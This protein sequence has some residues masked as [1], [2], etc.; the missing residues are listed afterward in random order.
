MNIRAYGFLLSQE[1][2][3]GVL[4]HAGAG[5]RRED[6]FIDRAGLSNETRPFELA[7]RDK[8][9]NFTHLGSPRLENYSSI[10]WSRVFRTETPTLITRC[11][12]RTSGAR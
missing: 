9:N 8:L 11:Y 7:L 10:T 4:L 5:L 2:Q 3:L 1:Q 6:A 12:F